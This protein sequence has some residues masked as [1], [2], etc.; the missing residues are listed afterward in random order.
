MFTLACDPEDAPPTSFRSNNEVRRKIDAQVFIHRI[1]RWSR[2]C[3]SIYL[4]Q[5][6][7]S[8]MAIASPDVL[9][10][11]L[12]RLPAFLSSG[13]FALNTSDVPCS[14]VSVSERRR[15]ADEG[16]RDKNFVS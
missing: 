5:K 16:H 6:S 9:P 13:A 7:A 2:F 3:P 15:E 14:S 12:R 8:K 11:A 4:G 1:I 10:K